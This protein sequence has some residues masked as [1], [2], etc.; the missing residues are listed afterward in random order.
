MIAIITENQV[1]QVLIEEFLELGYTWLHGGDISPGGFA[2]E[3]E[4]NEVVLKHRLQHAIAAINPK[5]PA[6]A[7]EEALRKVLR[8]D[9]PSL[10]QN[11]YT[12]HRYLTDGVEVEFRKGDRIA[13]DKVWLIDYNKP[14]NNEFL[15]VNQFTVIEGNTN[16]RPDLVL[17]VNGLPL[18]VIELKNAADE[19]ADIQAAFNQLQTY[20]QAIPSL[21][22]YNALLIAS[23]GWEAVFGSLTSPRQFFQPWKSIDGMAL[24][25]DSI[26]QVEVMAKGLLNKHVMLD[27]IR[28]FTV[29]QQDQ[30]KIVKIVPR[31]HQYFAVNKALETTKLA[32]A[33]NGDRRA[34]VIWHT[35]GSGKSLTMVFYAGK[36]VLNLNNPTLVM[37]TDRNDLDGQLFD[38]FSLSQDLLRQ[39]PVQATSREEL[40]KLLAVSSGGIVFTTIQ[41]FFPEIIERV[42][43]GDGKTKG[44]TEQYE[45]LSDR[46]NIVVIADEAHRSQYDFI[47]GFARHM[48]DALPHASF[49]GFTGTPIEKT[50]KNTQAVFGDYIDVYDI[51]QAVDD[52][53]TVR[54][55]Y[56]NRLAKIDIKEEEKPRVDAEFEELTESE[57]LTGRQKLKAKWARLEAI[58]GNEHRIELVAKDIVKHYEQRSEALDGK[59][60]IVCMSRRI[61]VDLYNAIIRF[62]PEWHADED[63]EGVIKVVMTGSSSDP[64]TWQPHV[65]N[66]ER[67]KDIGKR[68]KDPKDGLKI[69]IV[70]D[71]WL[72]GFD[73]PCLHTLYID[74]P[75]RDHNLMQAIAR[76]NRVYKGKEGGLI[77]DYIGIATDLKRPCQYIPRAG[78]RA[79]LPLTRKKL[80]C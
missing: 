71:M 63:A 59:A 76:V 79:N 30:E 8:S 11:N 2:P 29:F 19:G 10:F 58:V 65:R 17:F 12:F 32:T 60:M 47:D 67:R 75:M 62:R 20:K 35:Q 27:L 41:K 73:V 40:K 16:K 1:E 77:V 28:H 33:E 36:L 55:Y 78:V 54:I 18:V 38:T 6:E 23:D 48:R 64:L 61:C 46:K 34:G 68:L 56:E 15:V 3:R 4:Y 69:A 44:I 72:T 57:E 50:D 24:A 43:L 7:H 39:T 22:H 53:A 21:F 42:E 25:D 9:S 31:Y 37:L 5:V 80:Q 66:K 49:I 70:R 51:Q 26:P 45:M 52:G 74:K 14:E 13:G